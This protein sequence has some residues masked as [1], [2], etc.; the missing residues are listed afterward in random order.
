[1]GLHCV[2]VCFK[3]RCIFTWFRSLDFQKRKC[4]KKGSL[5]GLGNL[6]HW[7]SW[8]S[9]VLLIEGLDNQSLGSQ[10][11]C[12]LKV[13]AVK[14]LVNDRSWQSKNAVLPWQCRNSAGSFAV[15]GVVLQFREFC[16]SESCFAVQGVALQFRE[17]FCSSGSCFAETTETK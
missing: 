10:S 16:S 8:Q 13:L 7:R 1:M 11:Y 3:F 5:L 17:S 12:W 4:E 6:V 14:G 2:Y 9:K 15:Q